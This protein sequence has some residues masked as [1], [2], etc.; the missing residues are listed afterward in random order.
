MSGAAFC[1]FFKLRSDALV[2][3]FAASKREQGMVASKSGCE[4]GSSC[5]VKMVWQLWICVGGQPR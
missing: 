4:F 5:L 1:S 2:C 3:F